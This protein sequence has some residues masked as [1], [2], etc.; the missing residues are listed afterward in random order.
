MVCDI[1]ELCKFLSIDSCQKRFLW[2][3]KGVDLFLHSVVG[4]VL[5]VGDMEKFPL[6]LSFEAWILFSES[7]RRVH[8]SQ[9]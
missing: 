5:Q 1:P 4:F 6:A 2:T 7:A 3:H 9:P 8:A